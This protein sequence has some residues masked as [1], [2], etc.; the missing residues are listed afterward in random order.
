M[1]LNFLTSKHNFEC[2]F[3][4]FPEVLFTNKSGGEYQREINQQ[5][6]GGTE[7]PENIKGPPTVGQVTLQVPYDYIKQARFIAINNNKIAGNLDFSDDLV[8]QQ[9][10]SAGVFVGAPVTYKNA[11]IVSIM[12]P[13]MDKG[14]AETAMLEVVCQPTDMI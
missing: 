1:S 14:S 9:L 11:D 6:T 8:V 10:N 5:H 2:Y 4:S 3:L 12:P 7:P 13:D